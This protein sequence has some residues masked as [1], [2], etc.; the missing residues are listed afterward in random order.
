MPDLFIKGLAVHLLADW[1]LQSDWMSEN[2]VS[3]RHPAAWL[4]SGIHTLGFLLVF[5]P[6]SA[7]LLGISHLLIDTRLPLNYLRKIMG[8]K[9]D[10]P[11]GTSFMIWQDQ[12]AHILLI[13]V[14]AYWL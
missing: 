5:P 3:L 10:G 6:L 7:L 12:V 9:A 11:Q 1:I 14:A 8:Q 4:H 2:K 13:Y